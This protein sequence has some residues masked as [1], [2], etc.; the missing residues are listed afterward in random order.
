M[1]I[2]YQIRFNW[3]NLETTKRV[4][5]KKDNFKT[6]VLPFAIKPAPPCYGY[7]QTYSSVELMKAMQTCKAD[8]AHIMMSVAYYSLF[9]FCIQ[10]VSVR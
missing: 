1:H 5:Q 2:Q 10:Y 8:Y 4:A 3:I 6:V 7:N 9:L